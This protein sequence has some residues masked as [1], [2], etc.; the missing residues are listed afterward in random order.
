[1][2]PALSGDTIH[3]IY[4]EYG[5]YYIRSTDG[6]L[7]WDDQKLLIDA[8]SAFQLFSRP[9]V[10]SGSNVYLVWG[11]IN[12]SG[13]ITSIKIRRSLDAGATWL[14]PQIIYLNDKPFVWLYA[15]MVGA[16]DNWVF[17]LACGSIGPWRLDYHMF[18]SSD[19]GA[20]WDTVRR[21][22]T[23]VVDHFEGD[24]YATRTAVYLTYGRRDKPSG[25]SD[26]GF[27][28][29][30]DMG[31][32]W[33][34]EQ[35]V[36]DI[37]SFPSR[38]ARLSADD[39]GNVYLCWEDDKYW[40]ITGFS[41]AILMRKSN[42]RGN[43]W[44]N[45]IRI[46]KLPSATSVSVC[47]VG[48]LV[49]IVWDDERYGF[50]NSTIQY[51]LSIDRGET[52]SSEETVGDTLD[53]D[54]DAWVVASQN[55]VHVVWA[56]SFYWGEAMV[57]YRRGTLLNTSVSQRHSNY[58]GDLTLLPCFPNPFNSETTVRYRI[59][60]DGKVRLTMYD[61]LGRIVKVPIERYEQI[62][63]HEVR[64]RSD[65]LTSGTYFLELWFDGKRL[66]TRIVILR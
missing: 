65:G 62:G 58:P 51:V 5:T 41:R 38:H 19:Y 57:F 52:W 23:D 30:T 8:D 24:L 53:L 45:E 21:V 32:T 13:A 16:V 64:I 34:S 2:K 33:S 60:G 63:E 15:P 18:R 37:D 48:P 54:I 7:H 27:I 14:D 9:L 1:M 56:S 3:V 44:S 4:V 49:H 17:V 55:K 36:S 22:T 61:L 43:T 42:D 59:P 35:V 29:S 47:N 20:T 50:Q 10:S 66:N 11:N 26:I 6:G 40:T 39:E 25:R 31:A 28:V 12:P 46:T